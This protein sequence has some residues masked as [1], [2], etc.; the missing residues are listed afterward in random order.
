MAI[1]RSEYINNIKSGLKADKEYKK[2][3]YRFK[4]EGKTFYTTFDYSD[5]SWNK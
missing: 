4:V 2:F 3:F 1:N 5:K